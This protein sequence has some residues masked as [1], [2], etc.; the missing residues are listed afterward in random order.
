VTGI[1][2][3]QRSQVLVERGKKRRRAA[4]AFSRFDHRAVQH[5]VEVG[6]R[7]RL[8]NL[9]PGKKRGNVPAELVL[10]R[11]GNV[12]G[13]VALAGDVHHQEDQPRRLDLDEVKE[14]A[15]HARAFVLHGDLQGVEL[16]DSGWCGLAKVALRSVIE[17]GQ[18]HF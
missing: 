11:G 4:H 18:L 17:K 5:D 16:G 6:R 9:V 10:H 3:R 14:I 15:A 12:H 8:V 2:V 7:L 13:F 1:H